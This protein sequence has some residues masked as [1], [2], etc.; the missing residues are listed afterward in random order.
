VGRLSSPAP[1]LMKPYDPQLMR[2][3][4]ISRRINHVEN[5]GEECSAPVEFAESQDRLFL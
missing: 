3:Y 5:D 2:C 4:P 1:E